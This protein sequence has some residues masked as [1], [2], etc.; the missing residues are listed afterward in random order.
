[1]KNKS[2]IFILV[3]AT[4]IGAFTSCGTNNSTTDPST[5][6]SKDT[7]VTENNAIGENTQ[8]ANPWKDC[9]NIDD[10]T[11]IAGFSID[12]PQ[13]INGYPNIT[14]QAVDNE[15]IQIIYTA[16]TDEQ[17]ILVRKG[18]G[19]DDISGDYNTYDE[20]MSATIGEYDV[21]LKS[22]DGKIMLATWTSGAYTYAITTP[23][24]SQEEMTTLIQQV[25]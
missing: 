11:D 25:Q 3:C 20:S 8:I 4:T 14:I 21:T 12:A 22:N 23:G 10:A 6:P 15:I 17:S 13:N 1:M 18:I 16:D 19:T 5:P 24:I 9:E 2:L 7:S